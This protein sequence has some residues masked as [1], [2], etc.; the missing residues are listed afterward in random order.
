MTLLKRQIQS[1]LEILGLPLAS[2]WSTHYLHRLTGRHFHIERI[3]HDLFY[4]TER[5]PISPQIAEAAEQNPNATAK[6]A[7]QAGITM[8]AIQRRSVYKELHSIHYHRLEDLADAICIAIESNT[9][10]KDHHTPAE[11]LSTKSELEKAKDRLA[12][13]EFSLQAWEE[14]LA[15]IEAHLDDPDNDGPIPPLSEAES[16]L[17]ARYFNQPD[18]ASWHACADVM[19]GTRTLAEIW[20][21]ADPL[22]KDA[23]ENGAW[24]RFPDPD[25]FNVW[26]KGVKK[27]DLAETRARVDNA[28][29]ALADARKLVAEIEADEP[30]DRRRENVV[31]IFSES[32]R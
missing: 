28:R 12:H 21:D 24:Q 3:Q 13:A 16:R 25:A 4:A 2:G 31:H 29:A 32:Q 18:I 14:D 20:Q 5:L 9:P 26:L 1:E 6:L 8:A 19:V 15:E 30:S 23:Y 17:L 11:I 22:A 27:H 10:L 7:L